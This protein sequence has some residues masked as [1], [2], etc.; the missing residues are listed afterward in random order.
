MLS[1]DLSVNAAC[2]DWIALEVFDREV[3]LGEEAGLRG[4]G[5]G[6]LSGSELSHL[7]G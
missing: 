1:R 6:A 4:S 3:R 5:G 7:R 2:A